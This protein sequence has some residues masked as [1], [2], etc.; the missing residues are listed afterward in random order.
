MNSSRHQTPHPSVDLLTTG[1][2]DEHEGYTTWR[3]TGTTDWLLI[4]TLAG[5][6]RFG[7]EGG[8][9]LA[10]PG[11]VT[12]LRPGA[13]HD[14]GV[15]STMRH[16][17]LLWTHFHPRPHWLSWLN[18]PATAPG[19]YHLSLKPTPHREELTRRFFECH[20]LARGAGRRRNEWAM[21][22]LEEVLLRCDALNPKNAVSSVDERIQDAME[23]VCQSLS[24]KIILADI[25]DA[26][27]L[28]TSRLSHLFRAQ[29]GLTPQQYL[30]LRRLERATQLLE[31][32]PLS[33]KQI[34]HRVGFDNPF[35][36][37][38]RFKRWKGISPA[39]FRAGQGGAIFQPV[40]E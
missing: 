34:A 6:G 25:A 4:H 36:F 23:F 28:S 18:W 32:T 26:A 8:E 35:Y 24:R 19:L 12:L 11:D 38:I 21:N 39:I 9:L 17:E 22:V 20:H 14:Y 10:E 15:E 13:R 1:H 16:W 27:G 31:L 7:Y 37:S 30:E 33:I 2:F 40:R 5:R 3:E 29:T